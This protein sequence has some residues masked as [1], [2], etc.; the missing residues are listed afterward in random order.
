[1]IF[2]EG[3]QFSLAG[4]AGLLLGYRMVLSFIALFSKELEEFTT[5]KNRKFAIVLLAG[6]NKNITRSL[7]SLSGI[8]YPKNMYDL[9]VVADSDNNESAQIAK[10]LGTIVLVPD[11]EQIQNNNLD[12]PWVFEQILSWDKENQYEAVITF[13]AD[14]LVTGNYLE[15]MNYYLEQG[16]RVV[17]GGYRALPNQDNW[18]EEILQI[19]LFIQNYVMPAG[20]KILGFSTALKSNGTCFSTSVLRR[21][22]WQNLFKKTAPEL[23]YMMQRDGIDIEFAPEAVIFIDANP[24]DDQ[25]ITR[26][27]KLQKFVSSLSGGLRSKKI[28]NQISIVMTSVPTFSS[29]MS[30]VAVMGTISVIT[31]SLGISSLLF[32][33]LWFVMGL[34]GIV[35]LYT[36]LTMAGIDN[37]LLKAIIFPPLH[38]FFECRRYWKSFLEKKRIA[39]FEKG[40]ES[41][42]NDSVDD[43]EEIIMQ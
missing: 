1:M 4:V 25:N 35:H 43:K 7:Y 26:R 8:V 12:L 5:S 15:V 19:N 28:L 27:Q 24:D 21:Y 9:I 40:D 37:K 38:L 29:I 33:G 36:G 13:N 10:K 16:N 17:Q 32:I 22:P 3:L 31:W 23:G 39:F 2:L 20:N 42:S 34:I 6:S 14:D 11:Y 30:L 41:E 18:E